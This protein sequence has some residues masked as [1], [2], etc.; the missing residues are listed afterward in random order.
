MQTISNGKLKVSV[1]EHGATLD[2]LYDVV[3]DKQLLWQGSC[4]SWTGKDVVLFPFVGR[5][6]DGYYTVD[7]KR[8]E[9]N[10]H[11]LC[12]YS[13]FEVSQHT[14]DSVTLRLRYDEDTLLHYPYK[15]DFY[16]TRRLVEDTLVTDM[17]VVNLDDK[18][19][20]FGLGAHPAIAL[21]CTDMG[22]Y[23]EMSGN[24][25]DFGKTI[26][27]DN[28]TLQDGKFIAGVEK[29]E[30]FSRLELTKQLMQKYPTVMLTGA[31]ISE[32]TLVRKDGVKL[33]FD[34]GAA[35]ILG[36]WSWEKKGGYYCIEPWLS[37]PDCAQF[38]RELSQKKGILSLKS[39][40]TFQYT[41]SVTIGR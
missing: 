26:T 12:D 35:P 39:K 21:P 36:L 7:G 6:Q 32:F 2:S 22:D 40:D 5:L 13:L 11:G 17:T 1:D 25:L 30:S 15:F 14:S 31:D 38:N 23:D 29:W 20:Y 28:L 41:W 16:I 8:Y 10:I 18:T 9:M 19:M 37:I 33:H 24:Y 4:D 27:P 3:S 34:I